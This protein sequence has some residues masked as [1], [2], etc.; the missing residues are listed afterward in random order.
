MAERRRYTRTHGSGASPVNV[1]IDSGED[2]LF[3][4]AEVIDQ[5]E[6]GAQLIA[7]TA[8]LKIGSLAVVKTS[9]GWP[10]TDKKAS[11]KVVWVTR[12]NGKMRFGCEYL[13]PMIGLPS[14]F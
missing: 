7:K 10:L 4:K 14:F 9:S 3:F 1:Q 8:D 13:S 11:A 6:G 2:S 5:S 12:E